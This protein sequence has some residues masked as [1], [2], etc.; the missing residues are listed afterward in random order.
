MNDKTDVWMK[1]QVYEW[2]NRRMNDKA[3]VWMKNQVYEWQKRCDLLEA[4]VGQADRVGPVDQVV[5]HFPEIK[6]CCETV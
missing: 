1:N 5:H 2:Q 3:G 4:L 6:V